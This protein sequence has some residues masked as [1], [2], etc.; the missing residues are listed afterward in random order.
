MLYY[1]LVSRRQVG[2]VH[3]PD[4]VMVDALLSGLD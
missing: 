4:E 3:L 1:V 2:L